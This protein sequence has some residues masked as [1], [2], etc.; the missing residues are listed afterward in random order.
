MNL[1]FE[2]MFL[3]SG[4]V[5]EVLLRLM[6]FCTFS[7]SRMKEGV[8]KALSWLK[9]GSMEMGVALGLNVG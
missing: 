9:L 5:L 4:V 1:F 7:D 8:K 3:K 2:L 6:Q